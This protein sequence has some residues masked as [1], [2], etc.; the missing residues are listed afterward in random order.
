MNT[1]R[2]SSRCGGWR[3]R[4]GAITIES[5]FV[6]V[7]FILLILGM[8]DLGFAVLRY[9]MYSNAARQIARQTIVHGALADRLGPWGP[10]A[11]VG[12]ASSDASPDSDEGGTDGSSPTHDVDAVGEICKTARSMLVGI[13][14][15]TVNL[16][17]EW[18]DGGNDPMAG[19]R[20]Q[21]TVSSPYAT[22]A[23]RAFGVRPLTISATSTMAIAH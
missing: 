8:L 18:I 23:T 21:V 9:H 19:H 5:A 7:F 20:T 17:V 3:L 4:R 10:D 2:R 13:D 12:T 1:K 11:F 16:R 15:G 6:M 14:P 22:W